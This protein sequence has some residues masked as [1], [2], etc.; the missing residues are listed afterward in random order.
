MIDPQ[1]RVKPT[2]A[3]SVRTVCQANQWLEWLTVADADQILRGVL[4][5]TSPPEVVVA[6]RYAQMVTFTPL[7][8][9]H[10]GDVVHHQRGTAPRSAT[11]TALSNSRSC[12]R[13][14]NHISLI[15]HTRPGESR[16]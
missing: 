2:V 16:R 14:A 12:G 8:L 6:L 1:G 11:G 10:S 3:E 7:Q 9:T 5:R 13:S 4:A 15:C